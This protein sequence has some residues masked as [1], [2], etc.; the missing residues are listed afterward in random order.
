MTIETPPT[1]H[2]KG[3]TTRIRTRARGTIAIMLFL[4]ASLVATPMPA[5]AATTD[6]YQLY[7]TRERDQQIIV[8]K[9]WDDGLTNDKRKIGN[10]D[11]AD[12]LGMTIQTSVPQASIRTYTITYDANGGTFG[13]EEDGNDITSGAVPYDAKNRPY[14][15]DLPP[16]VSKYPTPERT[17]GYSFVGWSTDKNAT[18]PDPSITLT[19]TLTDSWMN[20]RTDGSNTTLYAVW[21]DIHINYAVMAYGIRV[22][23]DESGYTMSITFGPAL[24][25][26]EFSRYN[27]GTEDTSST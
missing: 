5:N 10:T 12:L 23:E 13:T 4:L 3:Y 15:R 20:T 7:D 14:G 19:N 18:E 6:A 16:G 9:A 11:Y 22:D 26:P 27:N 1:W 8:N 17:D 24:G 21:K 2:G 25:Y